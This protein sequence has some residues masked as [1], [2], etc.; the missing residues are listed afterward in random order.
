MTKLNE[1][2]KQR[3]RKEINDAKQKINRDLITYGKW[4]L[5]TSYMSNPDAFFDYRIKLQDLIEQKFNI[6]D[7]IKTEKIVTLILETLFKE[8]SNGSSEA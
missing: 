7:Q 6:S 4:I 8:Q 5:S 2:Y 3:K 1:D